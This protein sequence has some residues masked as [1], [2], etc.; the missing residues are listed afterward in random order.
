MLRVI[1]RHEWRMLGADAT[2]WMLVALLGG[3]AIYGVMNGLAWV[4]F[5]QAT[6][7]TALADE[8][9]E[10]AMKRADLA[11][12][13]SGRKHVA[14]FLDPRT[15]AVTAGVYHG[16]RYVTAPPAPLGALAIGQSDLYPSY[17][18]VTMKSKQA[19]LGQDEVDNP[20]SLLA[21]RFDLSFVLIY[22]YPLVILALSFN[23]LSQEKEH[24]TLT[25][26][27]SQPISLRQYLAAK[28]LVRAALV[29]AV[30][31]LV[32][33]LAAT[34]GG[35]PIWAPGVWWRL[36][37]WIV[38]VVVYGV[39][40]FALAVLINTRGLSSVTNALTLAGLWLLFLLIVPT[41]LNA[42][43][44][45]L[46][47]MPSR[48][49]MIQAMRRASDAA[50]VRAGELLGRYFQDHPDLVRADA[51]VNMDDVFSRQVVVLED[52]EARIQPV[53]DRFS[54]QLAG[55]QHLAFRAQ[56][57][58]PAMVTQL[59]F[60]D[61]AGTSDARYRDFLGQV[62]AF[63]RSWRGFFYPRILRMATL[64]E[65]DYDEMPHFTYR[66]EPDALVA[67][68]AL[69]GLFGLFVPVCLLTLLARHQ[70]ARYPVVG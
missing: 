20:Q 31:V 2:W 23:V 59:I 50:N 41:L 46:Y 26:A 22:L 17:V 62:E 49:E 30:A 5:Q 52:T 42:A 47:P 10:L 57:V 6:I 32:S 68:R 63:H 60:N 55:R 28:V 9:D 3:G 64:T 58:S 14:S 45:F 21:G 54:A 16:G 37:L 51:P 12:L 44:M 11:D 40:W 1:L 38:T 4:H 25:L 66:A 7:A 70:I 39:F 34:L 65:R 69:L 33:V 24:G 53:L 48:A 19:F 18:Q 27:L 35:V 15:P 36:G 29:I 67:R 13:A 56:Y 61:L 8:H 43:T